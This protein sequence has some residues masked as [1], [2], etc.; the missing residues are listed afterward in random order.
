M[1]SIRDVTMTMLVG[2]SNVPG[3]GGA[4]AVPCK[5]FKCATCGQV[6]TKSQ[7][8]ERLALASRCPGPP[9]PDIVRLG[10]LNFHWKPSRQYEVLV[11]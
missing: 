4:T 3:S 11:S 5:L 6:A 8:M 7:G 9:R 2:T 1:D 10:I